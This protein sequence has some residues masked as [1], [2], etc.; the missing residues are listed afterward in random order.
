M[1]DVVIIKRNTIN[2]IFTIIGFIL[3]GY[4]LYQG[5][6]DYLAEQK[7]VSV[8][9]IINS[10]SPGTF[11]NNASITYEVEGKQYTKNGVGL[12]LKKNLT[13][14]DRTKIKYNIDNPNQLIYNDHLIQIA[15]AGS[16][17]LIFMAAFLPK[18]IK[19]MK[20]ESN[21]N[22]LKKT[23][24]KI[25]ANIQDIVVNNQAKKSKGYFPY[26]LR[27]RYYNPTDQK[28]Y[29]FESLD[30]YVN[31]NELISKYQ[32]KVVQVYIDK[33]NTSNYY[34]DLNTII[35]DYKVVDPHEF[36]EEYYKKQKALEN[37]PEEE[38]SEENKEESK[39][40]KKN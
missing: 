40:E 14:G 18:R 17:A 22:R 13:V 19:I 23:G 33:E 27:A 11:G 29:L 6:T 37:P 20:Q 30:T 26:H 4:A 15:V 31:I 9:A 16:F 38:T 8:D 7:A 1:K 2:L 39:D 32:T 36:M 35:P 12:G 5:V 25:P 10:I 24:L 28:D 21:I 34:M 3:L